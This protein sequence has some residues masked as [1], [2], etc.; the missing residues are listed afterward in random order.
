MNE[1]GTIYTYTVVYSGSEEFRDRTP[2]LI[3]LVERDGRRELAWIE[4]YG[5]TVRAAIG[6]PVDFVR[7]DEAGHH[8]YRLTAAAG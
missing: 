1:K 7:T 6:D 5:E 2:Y 3:G 8:F 4:G